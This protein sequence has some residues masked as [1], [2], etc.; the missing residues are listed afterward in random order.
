MTD[1]LQEL[2]ER[3]SSASPFDRVAIS[4]RLA[5]TASLADTIELDGETLDEKRLASVLTAALENA[6]EASL[7]DAADARELAALLLPVA[8]EDPATVQALAA[9]VEY[10]DQDDSLNAVEVLSYSG[11]ISLV[12]LVATTQVKWTVG[13]RLRIVKKA[14]DGK[15]LVKLIEIIERLSK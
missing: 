1:R 15:T 10:N 3:I 13:E 6:D 4:R 14:L 7:V 8:L 9:A 5:E 12:I 2:A 11:A